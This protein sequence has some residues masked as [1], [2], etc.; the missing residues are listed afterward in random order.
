MKNKTLTSL[1]LAICLTAG[2]ASHTQSEKRWLGACILGQS[3]DYMTTRY[4]LANGCREANPM[5]KEANEVL[6][7]KIALIG[8]LYTAGKIYPEDRKFFYKLGTYLGL[9]AGAWNMYQINQA[10]EK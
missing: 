2:C 1:V 9:G 7:G 3:A 6:I 8:L 5:F 4:G 10:R